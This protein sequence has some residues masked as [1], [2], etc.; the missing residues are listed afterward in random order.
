M[1]V[2]Q[3]GRGRGGFRATGWFARGI[4]TS[5]LMAALLASASAQEPLPANRSASAPAVETPTYY[6]F[7]T[8][9]DLGE[10]SIAV[11]SMGRE[12]V[13][14]SFLRTRESRADVVR[15]GDP[16]EVIYTVSGNTL[17]LVRLLMLNAGIPAAGPPPK[18]SA[19]DARKSTGAAAARARVTL[20]TA[21]V[22]RVPPPNSAVNLGGQVASTPPVIADVPLGVAGGYAAKPIEPK[23]EP[24]ARERPGLAC[25]QSIPDWPTRPLRIAV[26]DFRYPTEREDAHDIGKASGGSGMA[27]GDLVFARLKQLPGFEVERGDRRRLD[28]S[29]I[30]GAARIGRELGVDAV[31]EGTFQPIQAP[32]DDEGF[33]GK[34]T[35]YAL[36]AGLVDTC[37]GQ[38]LMKMSSES[39]PAEGNPS[40]CS[41]L[42]VTARQA[43]DPE[44]YASAFA[45]P[46]DALLF[47]LEHNRSSSGNEGSVGVVSAVVNGQVVVHLT[48]GAS[49]HVGQQLAVHATRLAKNP[50][51][52]TLND[53]HDQE[54][55][56]M[57]VSSVQGSTV[58]G[59]FTGDIPPKA[60][61]AMEVVQP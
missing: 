12:P 47:P 42:S 35:G 45:A 61:D 20:P 56:R 18:I 15:P 10:H 17:R 25:N 54:I 38:V 44:S 7:G 6:E 41:T 1:E 51:T 5:L 21:V 36:R 46:V 57:S 43:D 2:V 22:P 30:A 14:R 50:I 3:Q 52:Y 53:L 24:V 37:T 28:R 26:L 27:V 11:R 8:V 60:G 23:A 29:D 19:A 39:C 9:V 59:S 32:P 55:G 34:L 48:G 16:V 58:T 33:P 49:V 31:L 4:G 40:R 13:Q